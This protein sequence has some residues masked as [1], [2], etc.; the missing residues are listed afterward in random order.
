MTDLTL[1]L[2][3]SYRLHLVGDDLSGK[4]VLTLDNRIGE[5]DVN[6]ETEWHIAPFYR[7]ARFMESDTAC[8]GAEHQVPILHD[9]GIFEIDSPYAADIEDA[10]N[11]VLLYIQ[12]CTPTT[13]KMISS[14]V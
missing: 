11:A 9:P 13:V 1:E 10:I 3:D 4:G 6:E 8:N 7:F 5:N 12:R 2:N 14:T